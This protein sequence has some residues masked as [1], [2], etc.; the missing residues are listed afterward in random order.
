MALCPKCKVAVSRNESS[1]QCSTCKNVIHIKC[2]NMNSDSIDYMKSNG[3]AF[4]C[5]DCTK[6]LKQKR[7]D[8]TPV[9][10]TPQTQGIH[11]NKITIDSDINIIVS[12]LDDILK[13]QIT[14]NNT[15][16]TLSNRIRELEKTLKE[17]ESIIQTLEFKINV[18]E[19]N[20]RACFIE[21]SASKIDI[22]LNLCDIENAYRKPLRQ[23]S[24]TPQIVVEFSFKRK[25]DEF[26]KKRGKIEYNNSRIFINESLTAYNRK[27]FWETRKKAKELGYR[28]I[29]TS[30]GRIFCKKDEL[31]KKIQV[32]NNDDLHF[33]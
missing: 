5:E 30:N 31:S 26:F 24:E 16:T 28:Y 7:D 32:R 9:K 13:K 6:K 19:Q 14:T 23:N 11:F 10:P 1:T 4:D 3:I 18:L 12:T 27:L 25:R 22:D 17:K 21:I 20:E 29:W 33:L 8:C 2:A 15:L